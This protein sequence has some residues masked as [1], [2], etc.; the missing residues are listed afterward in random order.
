M[1]FTPGRTYRIRNKASNGLVVTP[2]NWASGETQ[3]QIYGLQTDGNRIRQIWHVMPLDNDDV[4]IVNK[5][6]GLCFNVH[7]N[8]T[9]PSTGVQQ[10]DIQS[11]AVNSSQKWMLRP[12]TS[13]YY[14]VVNKKSGLELTPQNWGT[15]PSTNLQQYTPGGPGE[16]ERQYW[17][18]EVEDEYPQITGLRPVDR[19]PNDIGDVIR[20][21][22]FTEP[23]RD[24]TPEVLIGQLAVPFFTI[25]D[26]SPQWQVDNSPY[27]IL[28]RYGYWQKVFFYEHPGTSRVTKTKKV[29]VGL[30]TSTG[31]TVE[32]T[33][34]ISVTAEA[35]FAYKGFS[36]SLSTTYSRELK[37]TTYTGE[38]HEHSTED[39]IEREYQADHV[40][41]AECLW[42]RGDR[43]TVE[44]MDGTKVL[45]WN[46]L[47]PAVEVLD[48]HRG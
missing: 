27:Y 32:E 29:T 38:V 19:D 5:K 48:G 35:S 6:T 43:Y 28:K 42:Y 25:G 47:N 36:A 7:Q 22:G 40:R 46:T 24:S 30:T 2:K 33:T 15:S 1:A 10:Y 39:T 20:L 23:S 34:G 3:L 41:I 31:K 13:G 4:M 44:R 26:S 37:V 17:A 16:R 14:T 21:T 9:A 18:L 8:S 11:P 12:A 45:E